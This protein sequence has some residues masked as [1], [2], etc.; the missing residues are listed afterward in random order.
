MFFP[1]NDINRAKIIKLLN[2]EGLTIINMIVITIEIKHPFL[3]N[4]TFQEE[5]FF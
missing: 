4:I 3:V 2:L 1:E 5:M